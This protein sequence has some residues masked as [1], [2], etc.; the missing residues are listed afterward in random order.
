MKR[1]N[2][3]YLAVGAFVLAMIVV[4]LISLYKIT[5]R[6]G[7]TTEYY[8]YY[9]NVSGIKQGTLVLYEG[10]QVGQ[11]EG[12][13][14]EWNAGRVSYRVALGI[15]RNWRIP[16]DSVARIVTSGL[17]AAVS[18]DIR[19]GKNATYLS[20]GDAIQGEE[21]VRLFDT[22][23]DVAADFRQLSH[24]GIKPLLTNLNEHVTILGEEWM[25]LTTDTIR[26][27]LEK[28][29]EL[30]DQPELIEDTRSLLAKL[31]DS[32]D[33]LREVLNDE[34]RETIANILQNVEGASN[35]LN[36]L[37]AGITETRLLMDGLLTDLE[38]LVAENRTNI[39]RSIVDLQKSLQ[40]V[41]E[42][43]DA[44]AYHLE[45]ST[46]NIHEFSRQIRE[47]PAILLRGAPASDEGVTK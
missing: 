4:F 19:E 6:T 24:E 35:N 27:L 46:R 7:P 40:V 23:A 47:N 3:N 8:V 30:V 11:V 29:N 13:A 34:N 44:V 28:I 33:R 1:E 15:R 22:L 2:L 36:A 25:V 45:G 32:A 10:F 20:P 21:G 26:P 5:G 31:N 18:I 14:P 9:G 43:I 12:I 16:T 38:T 39:R 42:H 41:S 17:L 37:L